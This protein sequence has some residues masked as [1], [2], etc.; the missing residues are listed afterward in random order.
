MAR[1][2]TT[3]PKRTATARLRRMF[4]DGGYVRTQSRA[5]AREYGTD[6]YKKGH[7]VRLTLGSMAEA[8]EARAM[9]EVVGLRGGKPYQ[10]HSRVIQPVYGLDAVEW[11]L[12]NLGKD[13]KSLGFTKGGRRRQRRTPVRR[14]DA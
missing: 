10:K 14:D 7:E 6:V 8:Q 2:T 1:K 13:P 9:L 3:V 5:D 12:D 4:V 11:F